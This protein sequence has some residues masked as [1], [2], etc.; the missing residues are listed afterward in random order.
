ME[1]F[2]NNGEFKTAVKK[3]GLVFLFGL[4]L[5]ILLC[6][7]FLGVLNTGIARG[8]ESIAGEILKNHPELEG[9]MAKAV[10]Q[11]YSEESALAGAAILQK[12][13]YGEGMPLYS[14]PLLQTG[15]TPVLL[16]AFGF[17][18]VLFI[19]CFIVL[20]TEYGKIYK[21]LQAVTQSA[22]KVVEGDIV[23]LSEEGEGDFYKLGHSFNRMAET[24]NASMQSAAAEKQFLRNA[25]ADIS[26]QIKTPLSS[27]LVF[28][29]LMLSDE[30][31]DEGTREDFLAKSR[32]QLMRIQWLVESLL[33]MAML[34]SGTINFQK[35]KV[36]IR[37]VLEKSVLPVQ[38]LSQV[39]GVSIRILAGN[40]AH[41]I[42]DDKWTVEACTNIVKN[43]VEHS[44]PGG[45]VEVSAES[46][47]LFT[48]I[49]IKDNGGGIAEKDLPHIF[50][51]FYRGG[52][53]PGAESV[54]VGL[55]LS[56]LIVEGQ[57]GLLFARSEPGKG[58]VFEI[59]LLHGLKTE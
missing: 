48:K 7:V 58:S 29:E 47:G 56:K 10:T 39:K 36:N 12:Y 38:A 54:G 50:E 51:R 26:H 20:R 18:L 9:E 6:V 23:T 44:K 41:M 19:V 31:M 49:R 2:L 5:I 24:V 45:A 11:G 25:I 16:C 4:A 1:I 43:A 35:K 28:N 40:D 59:A 34:E 15:F 8:N 14:Q 30:A 37:D 57:G 27:I 52:Q 3:L 17:I 22:E 13:G 55:S 53:T 33:K 21:K 46:T 42:C 32:S